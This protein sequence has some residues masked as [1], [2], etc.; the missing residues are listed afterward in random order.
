MLP[1]EGIQILLIP[2]GFVEVTYFGLQTP[3][4]VQNGE[5]AWKSETCEVACLACHVLR[6]QVHCQDTLDY[7]I[8]A[9]LLCV[10]KLVKTLSEAG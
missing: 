7:L 6:N 10:L 5:S 2:Q 1:D 4:S 9:A 8:S 3:F